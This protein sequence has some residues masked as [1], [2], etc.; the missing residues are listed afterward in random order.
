M[1]HDPSFRRT[2]F[3][4]GLR[5]YAPLVIAIIPFGLVFGIVAAGSDVGPW[6]G[7]ATSVVIF[8]GAAQLATLQLID[9]GAAGAVVIA[10]ALVINARHLMYSAAL[11]PGF[12]EFPRTARFVLPYLLTDQAFAISIVRFGQ[13]EEPV[14]RRWYF[15]GAGLG[16]WV[17]W[18]F[19]TVTGIVVGAQVPGSWS[20]D[21]AIPLMFVILLVPTIKGRPE[22]IAAAV[23]AGVAVAA[24]NAPYGLGLMIGAVSGV[25]AGVVALR[26]MR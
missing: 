19:S 2:A 9:A 22:L 7:G 16:L 18:Q 12:R 13:V 14:Y 23:G 15:T 8:A 17:T 1:T 5:A 4:D 24:A 26:V 25:V 3:N 10:T 6:L 21:F 11:A 20:L